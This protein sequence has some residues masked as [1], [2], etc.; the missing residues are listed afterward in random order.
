M[1]QQNDTLRFFACEHTFEELWETKIHGVIV[2]SEQ[3]DDVTFMIIRDIEHFLLPIKPISDARYS[4]FAIQKLPEKAIRVYHEKIFYTKDSVLKVPLDKNLI[5]NKFG[6][7][8]YEENY[9]KSLPTEHENPI[10]LAEELKTYVASLAMSDQFETSEADI[11]KRY[12]NTKSLD[13]YR[14]MLVYELVSQKSISK[15]ISPILG[16]KV[17]EQ[18]VENELNTK[19]KKGENEVITPSKESNS[20][21]F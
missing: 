21:N 15:N 19:K 14:L 20:D 3:D 8:L 10:A 16:L 5:E 9:L 1:K 7:T 13:V 11:I 2:K 6:V 18:A 4:I 12:K 17:F